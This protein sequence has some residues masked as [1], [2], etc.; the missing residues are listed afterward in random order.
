MF[1]GTDKILPRADIQN[2]DGSLNCENSEVAFI[3]A[4]VFDP[5]GHFLGDSGTQGWDCYQHSG[6]IDGITAGDGRSIIILAKN[7]AGDV[8]FRGEQGNISVA[9]GQTVKPDPVQAYDFSTKIVSP[10]PNS[11]VVIRVFNLE[12]NYVDG[13]TDYEVAIS[14][15]IDFLN[16]VE[17]VTIDDTTY[18][19]KKLDYGLVYY[20][21]VRAID[22]FGN[23][24]S[25]SDVASFYV[26]EY[27][28]SA[29]VLDGNI[30][31]K[32]VNEN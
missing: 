10:V 23:N 28:N 24:G 12:W 25:W 11:T 18:N 16:P 20:W 4:A 17:S 32:T 21:R 27:R 6:V 1:P 29:P 3:Y 13:A 26:D 7:Q 9:A 30:G 15:S 5:E 14:S 2:P 22:K 31:D 8:I 19:P